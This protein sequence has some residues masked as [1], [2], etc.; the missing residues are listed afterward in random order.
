RPALIHENTDANE[1]PRYPHLNRLMLR[2]GGWCGHAHMG[3]E[4]FCIWE[5]SGDG[6]EPCASL[7]TQPSICLHAAAPPVSACPSCHPW[8]SLSM[9]SPVAPRSFLPPRSMSKSSSQPN[10]T[11]PASRDSWEGVVGSLE[12]LRGRQ[13]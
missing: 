13:L 9:G 3:F 7:P 2:R 4:S 1:R 10:S 12:G 8:G 5:L 11:P 6:V